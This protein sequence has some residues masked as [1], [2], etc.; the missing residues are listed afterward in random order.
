VLHKYPLQ[1]IAKNGEIMKKFLMSMS[2]LLAPNRETLEQLGI[3]IKDIL[4]TIV[5]PILIAL[6]GAGAIYIV[7][8]G[9]QFAKSE[10][11][12]KRTEAK[13]RMIN[14]AVGVVLILALA[15]VCTFIDWA[16]FIQI[17]GYAG[18]NFEG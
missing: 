10:S 16:S 6:G 8:L 4:S 18:E 12:E 14:L 2:R 5:G 17:F 7:V 15:S 1:I 11:E 3:Q 13:K 9:V